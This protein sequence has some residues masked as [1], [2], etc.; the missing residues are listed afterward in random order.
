MIRVEPDD[1]EYVFDQETMDPAVLIRTDRK[2]PGVFVAFLPTL[3]PKV[4]TETLSSFQSMRWNRVVGLGF[5]VN[6]LT[7]RVES[8]RILSR[9]D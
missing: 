3:I 1:I 9:S 8:C 4:F 5:V 7:R 6:S 2:L